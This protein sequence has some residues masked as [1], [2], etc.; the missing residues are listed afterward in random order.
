VAIADRIILFLRERPQG[1]DDGEIASALGLK[2]RQQANAECKALVERGLVVREHFGGHVVNRIAPPTAE[3][4]ATAPPATEAG[5][6]WD[7]P[8]SWEGNVVA[9]VV[10]HYAL[11]GL[12][13]EAELEDKEYGA[14]VRV[15]VDDRETLIAVRGAPPEASHSRLAQARAAF[16]GAILD[17]ALWRGEDA[18]RRVVLALPDHVTYRRLVERSA[19][20]LGEMGAEVLWVHGDGSVAFGGAAGR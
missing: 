12:A 14:M 19:W 18:G 17:L 3:S 20:V 5:G 16:A 13:A 4:E 15:L 1:A 10:S 6:R 11:Q 7:R 2:R 9:R 8:W